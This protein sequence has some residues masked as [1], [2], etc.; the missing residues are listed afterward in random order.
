M[1]SSEL[2]YE[3]NLLSAIASMISGA[4]CVGAPLALVIIWLCS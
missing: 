4:I 2:R 3:G 1:S